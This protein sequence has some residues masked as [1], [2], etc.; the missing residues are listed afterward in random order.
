MQE[1]LT[2]KDSVYSLDNRVKLLSSKGDP[3]Q[4][5]EQELG[6][7]VREYRKKWE[8]TSKNLLE[9][10]YP[11]HLN[12]ELAYGCNL[13]C[14]FCI[15]SLPPKAMNY[16]AKPKDKIPFEKYCQIIDEGLKY[17]LC[18]IALNGYNEPLLQ[19]DIVRYINY[20]KNA[21]VLDI[22]L[23]T[24]GLLLTEDLS[25]ELI[26]SGLT[27]IMFSIDA[28]TKQ[29]Y[30]RIRKSPHFNKV[31]NNILQ[32]IE[33]KKT[34]NKLLPLTR[35][36]FVENKINH[37][38]LK[39]FISFW[40]DKVDY[41]MIQSFC[42]PFVDNKEFNKIEDEYRFENIPFVICT[43]PFQ[44]LTITCDGNVL[45]CCSYYGLDLIM[46]NIYK[47]SLYNIWNGKKI[48]ELRL[49]VNSSKSQQPQ[50]CK[51]CRD[52]TGPER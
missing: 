34:K 41:F 19:K 21:G 28:A 49:K 42:N 36:S 16:T 27:I 38:E 6:P 10:P 22:S 8:A 46:G 12:I 29:T 52:S 9:I 2:M 13:R 50:A 40:K 3:Y 5:L 15:F 30:E 14:G 51:K 37:L 26:D 43:E 31:I 39:D 33:L 44:R 4:R 23:H 32:F 24:N 1:T 35:V 47:D 25:K 7:S 11:L 18:S 45:P 48:K 20:A 17:G